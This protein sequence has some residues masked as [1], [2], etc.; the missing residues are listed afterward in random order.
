MQGRPTTH[1][2]IFRILLRFLRLSN[3]SNMFA[4]ACV[5]DFYA[6]MRVATDYCGKA[7]IVSNGRKQEESSV[8]SLRYM[9]SIGMMNKFRDPTQ[10]NS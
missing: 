6:I 7:S 9:L 4:D 5:H 2:N 3:A 1:Y 10:V 8:G